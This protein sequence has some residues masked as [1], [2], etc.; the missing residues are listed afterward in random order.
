M[1]NTF[2]FLN[3]ILPAALSAIGIFS[4]SFALWKKLKEDYEVDQIFYLTLLILF[5]G[6]TGLFVSS[7]FLGDTFSFWGLF[8]GAL[9][10]GVYAV[11]K[12]NMRFFE[13]VDGAVLGLLLFLSL[14]SVGNIVKW[15]LGIQLANLL[16]FIIILTSLG[17][18][19][20]FFKKYRTLSWY[21]SGKIGFV[22]LAA[23]TV[24]FLERALVA[25]YLFLVLLFPQSFLYG[26]A[27]LI[28]SLLFAGII[29][30]RSGREGAK[31][32]LSLLQKYGK[33]KK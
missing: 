14:F 26:F 8:L 6:G 5:G 25:F 13:V 15:G 20:I 11:L 23:L 33:S 31:E 18:Y 17:S 12:L 9:L 2:P 21:I 24:Y 10:F 29:Y 32:I 4:F 1:L 27:S 28:L 19:Y 16:E 30:L 7:F 22:G 3:I